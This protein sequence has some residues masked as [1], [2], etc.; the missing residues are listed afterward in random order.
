VKLSP[1]VL[2]VL[3]KC[4]WVHALGMKP[5]CDGCAN[6]GE[7]GYCRGAGIADEQDG[8][9]LICHC[10]HTVVMVEA[11]LECACTGPD[12]WHCPGEE[13]QHWAESDRADSLCGHC[14][15]EPE[16]VA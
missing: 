8:D 12:G 2:S 5:S 3:E 10:G 7:E 9:E 1:P 13:S 15:G 16:A 6:D 11:P 4:R 14:G